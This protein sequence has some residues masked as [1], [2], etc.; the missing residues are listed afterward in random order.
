MPRELV[1]MTAKDIQR[2]R[3][4]WW[5]FHY[6]KRATFKA[7]PIGDQHM[8][9][10]AARLISTPELTIY[11]GLSG[12]WPAAAEL[13][14]LAHVQ[15]IRDFDLAN[16]WYVSDEGWQQFNELWNQLPEPVDLYTDGCV[17]VGTVVHTV[18]KRAEVQPR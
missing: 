8:Y 7:L 12:D 3:A 17:Q 9:Q 1:K 16:P 6:E 15:G 5:K 14:T 2:S 18:H 11:G 13:R 4:G 10:N